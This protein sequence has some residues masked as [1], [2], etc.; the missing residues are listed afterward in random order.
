MKT[1]PMPVAAV[2]PET[3]RNAIA[4]LKGLMRDAGGLRRGRTEGKIDG[5]VGPGAAARMGIV[6]L[7][8]G[9]RGLEDL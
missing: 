6:D 8:V 7:H 1:C 4:G 5:D 3:L 2:N 9:L